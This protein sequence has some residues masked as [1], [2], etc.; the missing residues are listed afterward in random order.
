[1][2]PA[3]F[4]AR[5]V[6]CLGQK[7]FATGRSFE[8]DALSLLVPIVRVL[9]GGLEEE[10]LIEHLIKRT[11]DQHPSRPSILCHQGILHYDRGNFD[12][13]EESMWQAVKLSH[14]IY[15]EKTLN[16]LTITLNVAELLIYQGKYERG[17]QL[18]ERVIQLA[19]SIQHIA[20]TPY[21]LR[22]KASLVCAMSGYGDN[23]NAE[24]QLR[25]ILGESEILLG[26]TSIAAL[27]A[28]QDL[29]QN[30]QK[31]GKFA[32]AEA[33]LREGL[34]RSLT[35]GRESPTILWLMLDL[36]RCLQHQQRYAEALPLHQRIL[37][38][39]TQ[40]YGSE[41][42]ETFRQIE[43]LAQCLYNLGRVEEALP[44]YQQILERCIQAYGTDHD[45][46]FCEMENLAHCLY[47]LGRDEEALPLYQQ[48]LERERF[49]PM[50]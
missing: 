29:A 11:T 9:K 39:Y 7:A 5:Q 18:L 47:N 50:V 3:E 16:S 33:Y 37:E 12:E 41:H 45:K 22:S 49:R 48:I 4:L 34:E 2:F 8:I 28:I 25:A 46:A 26:P 35:L 6:A 20:L 32:E 31:Q 44:L 40:V 1:M 24:F 13:A 17:K 14:Q 23:P 38:G 15:G 30:L 21:V 36:A 19:E 10:N 42:E 27:E 43:N